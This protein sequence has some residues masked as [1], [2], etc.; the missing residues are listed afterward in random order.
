MYPDRPADALK[1]LEATPDHQAVLPRFEVLCQQGRHAEAFAFLDGRMPGAGPFR[2][3]WNVARAR[4]LA[5][6]GETAKLQAVLAE[7]KQERVDPEAGINW[8]DLVEQLTAVGLRDALAE[9]VAALLS[10]NPPVPRAGPEELF[11]KL[12]PKTPL[13]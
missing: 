13:A 8:P 6:L 4:A 10:S 12:Y 9:Q 2:L 5:P 11:P 1:V 3:R 7:L